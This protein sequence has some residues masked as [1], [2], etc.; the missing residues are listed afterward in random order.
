VKLLIN[1]GIARVYYEATGGDPVAVAM[2]QEA[3][4]PLAR[5]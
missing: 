3:K 4:I 1:A 5:V 2:L